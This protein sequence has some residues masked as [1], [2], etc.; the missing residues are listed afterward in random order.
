MD[1]GVWLSGG[2]FCLLAMGTTMII[3]FTTCGIVSNKT[4]AILMGIVLLCLTGVIIA[5]AIMMKRREAKSANFCAIYCV[6]SFWTFLSSIMSFVRS[7]QLY[8]TMTSGTRL[9]CAFLIPLGMFLAISIFWLPFCKA[10]FSDYVPVT[11]DSEAIQFA[12]CVLVNT[13]SS[14]ISSLFIGLIEKFE[15][16]NEMLSAITI[17]SI[18][19]IFISGFLG[20]LGG[21]FIYSKAEKAGYAKTTE[22]V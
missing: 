8:T 17:R 5:G 15:I 11:P 9:G 14:V 3:S 13:C 16:E 2:V 4:I 21:L 22:A 20:T 7:G 1:K 18:A 19:S 10:L 6:I 12:V